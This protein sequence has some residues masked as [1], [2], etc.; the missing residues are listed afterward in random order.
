M[1]A[2]QKGFA[3]R[4]KNCACLRCSITQAKGGWPTKAVTTHNRHTMST[5]VS[6]NP[7]HCSVVATVKE[8]KGTPAKT[9]TGGK[10]GREASACS[11]GRLPQNCLRLL[12]PGT[13]N[14][15]SRAELTSAA[16]REQAQASQIQAISLFSKYSAASRVQV[17]RN[18]LITI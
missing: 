4:G 5:V 6:T 2:N 18:D 17:N 15:S 3:C 16:R 1:G 13:S 12:K 7:K 8:I 11:P 9:G 14:G 10:A